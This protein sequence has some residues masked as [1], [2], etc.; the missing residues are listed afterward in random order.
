M[1]LTGPTSGPALPSDA[2]EFYGTGIDTLFSGTRIYWLV[3]EGA[4]AK[5]I[6]TAS[7]STSAG[8]CAD[9]FPFTVIRED[10]STYFAAL[11]NGENNDNFFG[12]TVTSDA[13]DQTLTLAHRDTSSSQPLT[14][15]LALQGVTDSQLHS[16]AVQFNGTPVGTVEFFGEILS[17]QSVTIDPSLVTD[18]TN[19]VT[20]AALNGDNDVSVIQSI[21]LHYLHTYEADSNWLRATANAGSTVRISGFSNSEVRLFDITDPLN[22]SELHGKVAAETGSYA[23]SATVPAGAPYTRTILAFAADQLASP[24]ALT[25]HLPANHNR[26][27]ADIVMITHPGFAANLEP[28]VRL[29]ESQGHHV[30][31]ITTEQ[32]YDQYN[33][34]EHSP[35]A[36]RGFLQDAAQHWSRKPQ[37]VLL[38]GDASLD[39]RNYLGFGDLD[40]V[41]TRIIETAAFK[42]AS[43]DWFTDFL[44]TGYPT[45]PT[46]R[47]PVR[48][49]SDADLLVSKIVGYEQGHDAGPWT[50]QALLIADQNIDANFTTAVAAAATTLPASLQST[51]LLADGLDPATVR[52]QILT[53]LNNGS[54]LVNYNGHG[55]EQQWSFSDLFNSSDAASLNNGARLPVY[56]LIDC[57]NGLFQDVYE[58]SLAESLILAPNGGA[59]A[60]WASSGFTEQTPQVSMNLTFL[61][62]FALHPSEPLGRIVL[63]AKASTTDN[64]VRRTWILFG[65]PSLKLHV[66]PSATSPVSPNKDGLRDDPPYGSSPCGPAHICL[67]RE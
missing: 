36:L 5:R 14:L 48:T 52:S 67:R 24:A 35:F 17:T 25:R 34:G 20:L 31:V 27:G 55:A 44:Q 62:E 40:F 33:F 4:F 21:Q 42:T 12:D 60:V 50:S 7:P 57:L 58:Q 9:S 13:V 30:A 32:I 66:N 37:A 49:T 41:P 29:R 56:L 59:V 3:R 53:A 10:R 61:H 54:L 16:I 63:N 19:I 38:V 22:I 2:I 8:S 6:L 18:G 1:L 64:D 39:P 26:V 47:L 15:D 45:I 65:D 23:I 51:Q 43:D 28:L 11:L 46:G